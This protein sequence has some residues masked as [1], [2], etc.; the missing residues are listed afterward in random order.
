MVGPTRQRAL[1]EAYGSWKIICTRC[2]RCAPCASN[3]T[4]P[5]VGRSS[6]ATMRAKVV[7]P[8]PDSPT[9]LNVVPSGM[10][11]LTPSTDLTVR[12]CA[13]TQR[14]TSLTLR[15]SRSTCSISSSLIII[16]NH[17]SQ[18][19]VVCTHLRNPQRAQIHADWETG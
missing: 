11:K 14:L 13:W 9:R 15:Y 1:S 12:H 10:S 17:H 16:E 8:Q 19:H 6:P 18:R 7:L 4:A 3:A 5:A 2:G